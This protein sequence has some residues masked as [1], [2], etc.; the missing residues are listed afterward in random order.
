[1]RTAWILLLLLAG[2]WR[3]QIEDDVHPIHGDPDAYLPPDASVCGTCT[4]EQLCVQFFDGTCGNAGVKCVPI[5]VTGCEPSLAACSAE[6]EQAYCKPDNDI[7]GCM[8]R[9][10]SCNPDPH[11]FTCYGP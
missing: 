10:G 4:S 1:M 3:L 2:C 5:T 9:G 11:A 6:C 8:Y 7:F